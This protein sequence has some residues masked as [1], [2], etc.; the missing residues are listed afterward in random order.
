MTP[1]V[2]LVEDDLVAHDT[3]AGMLAIEG[4]QVIRAGSADEALAILRA[5]PAMVRIVVT[6]MAVPGD[7]G[8]GLIERARTILPGLP[9][10]LIT[11][12][13]DDSLCVPVSGGGFHILGR[14]VHAEE[15]TQCINTLLALAPRSGFDDWRSLRL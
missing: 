9:A 13:S 11:G 6:D 3:L 7:N 8:I 12:F 10:I 1:S 5:G 14:P 15:L 4:F 2:L